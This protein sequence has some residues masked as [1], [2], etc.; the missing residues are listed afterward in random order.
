MRLTFP[1]ILHGGSS[2]EWSAISRKALLIAY[3]G[4]IS[5]H[6]GILLT[7]MFLDKQQE[8]SHYHL[9]QTEEI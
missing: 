1:W 6:F 8:A 5:V 4:L 9:F 2:L 7:A 3:Q